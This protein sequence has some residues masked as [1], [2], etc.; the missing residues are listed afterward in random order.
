MAGDDNPI[1]PGIAAHASMTNSIFLASTEGWGV[2]STRQGIQ[3]ERSYKKPL[4]S[5]LAL[6]NWKAQAPNCLTNGWCAV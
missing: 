6:V 4:D 1:N 3:L 2:R 5:G